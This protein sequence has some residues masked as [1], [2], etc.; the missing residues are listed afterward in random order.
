MSSSNQKI[1]SANPAKAVEDMMSV[2]S[3]LGNVYARE[4]T[5][6]EKSDTESFL[7][8]QEE[9]FNAARLYEAGIAE[10]LERKAE[11]KTI[12]ARSKQRLERMQQDFSALA[13][14]NLEALSRMQRSVEKLGNTIR[15]AAKEAARKDRTFSYG[16]NGLV[17]IDENKPVSTGISETV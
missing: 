14:K 12:D 3:V 16:Q 7:S 13:K 11:I 6:L 15:S 10:L 4:T 1:L 17:D 8:L 9:K 2:I 5:A